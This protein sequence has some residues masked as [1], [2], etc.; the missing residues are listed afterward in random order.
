MN[1]LEQ[2]YWNLPQRTKTANLAGLR[3]L[4][5]GIGKTLRTPVS[6]L[7]KKEIALGG[8]GSLGVVAAAKGLA[9]ELAML[10]D[11]SA[12]ELASLKDTLMAGAKEKAL[13]KEVILGDT[14]GTLS[15][16]QTT[17]AKPTMIDRLLASNKL[18]KSGVGKEISR[19]K[20]LIKN[21]YKDPIRFNP[22]IHKKLPALKEMLYQDYAPLMAKS[23]A[24]ATATP[25]LGA[26]VDMKILADQ[27]AMVKHLNSPAST[28]ALTDI[29]KN[30][31]GYGIASKP[32]KEFYKPV[33][34]ELKNVQNVMQDKKTLLSNLY[35]KKAT[36][37]LEGIQKAKNI[38]DLS[39][40]YSDAAR[41]SLNKIQSNVEKAN[42]LVD[43][44][45][46]VLP[47]KALQ[48]IRS[49]SGYMPYRDLGRVELSQGASALSGAAENQATQVFTEKIIQEAAE[50][51]GKTG[52]KSLF[53]G[54]PLVG[55]GFAAKDVYQ[56]G[57]MQDLIAALKQ[58]YGISTKGAFSN[59]ADSVA[60]SAEAYKSVAQDL[61]EA[62][63]RRVM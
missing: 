54:V 9:P 20:S 51:A 18:N 26:G 46:R 41:T 35:A 55:A 34:Q 17:Q 60:P 59:I 23:Q 8:L 40:G 6:E 48:K 37:L 25:I 33:L 11:L 58:Q 13:I 52:V 62:I 19:Q 42:K 44:S 50:R 4:A 1:N 22:S 10:P 28:A 53:K 39:K 38:E 12:A 14:A 63:K 16:L 3:D 24:L 32:L 43:T 61:K 45:Y 15:K 27:L 21:L 7:S 31:S 29:V 36:T 57:K 49:A 56:A 30:P 47:E 5:K 2:H